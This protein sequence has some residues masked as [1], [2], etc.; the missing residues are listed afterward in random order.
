MVERLKSGH[1]I[2]V[3]EAYSGYKDST[4]LNTI[5]TLYFVQLKFIGRFVFDDILGKIDCAPSSIANGED[6][7]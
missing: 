3:D 5:A 2:K 6:S 7:I 4:V 1:R